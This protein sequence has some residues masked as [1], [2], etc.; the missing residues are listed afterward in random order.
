MILVITTVIIILIIIPIGLKSCYIWMD[1]LCTPPSSSIY[2]LSEKKSQL[3]KA[4]EYS[5]I[6]FTP[7]VN[8]DVRMDTYYGYYILLLDILLV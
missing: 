5:D 8:D 3:L 2:H 4:V 6:I 1:V 7:I